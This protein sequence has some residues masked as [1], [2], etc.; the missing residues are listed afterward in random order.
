M[1]VQLYICGKQYNISWNDVQSLKKCNCSDIKLFFSFFF[2]FVSSSCLRVSVRAFKYVSVY[3]PE[4][5]LSLIQSGW[6][7]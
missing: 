1:Y 3:E 5:G 4:M 2:L 6:L 7:L